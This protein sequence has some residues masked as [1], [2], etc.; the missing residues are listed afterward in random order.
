MELSLHDFIQLQKE[1]GPDGWQLYSILRLVSNGDTVFFKQ[2]ELA[3][4]LG[5]SS[6]RTVYKRLKELQNVQINT[7]PLLKQIEKRPD[8]NVYRLLPLEVSKIVQVRNSDLTVYSLS[9]SLDMNKKDTEVTDV[10]TT[11]EITTETPAQTAKPTPQQL[12]GYWSDRY[13]ETYDTKY[14]VS[15]KKDA[16]LMKRLL[17]NYGDEMLRAIIDVVMRMYDKK[18]KSAAY[19]RP[20]IGQLSSWIAQQA[21]PFAKANLQA[22]QPMQVATEQSSEDLLQALEEKGWF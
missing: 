1:I 12:I 7:K 4:L 6:T 14:V 17:I 21:E 16:P 15:W 20:T 13:E 5:V 18:W 11:A 2:D 9:D 22:T 10:P 19:T 8:G 3:D